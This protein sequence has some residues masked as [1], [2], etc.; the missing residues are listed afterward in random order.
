MAINKVNTTTDEESFKFLKNQSS[1]LHTVD[2]NKITVNGV[3]VIVDKP[4]RGDVMC[5]TKYKENGVLLNADK[6]EVIW[7]DGLSIE[8]TQLSQDLEPV[9]ICLTM[10]GNKALVRYKKERSFIWAHRVRKEIVY[11]STMN[12]GVEHS[13]QIFTSYNKAGDTFTFKSN[14]RNLFEKSE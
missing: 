7:I 6:Q 3:N 12:D 13:Y 4:K 9:G 14:S 5:I 11:S 10:K 1:I 8:P 2:T